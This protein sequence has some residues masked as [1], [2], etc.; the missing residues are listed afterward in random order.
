[1]VAQAEVVMV[2]MARVEA[3]M[4]AAAT[5]ETVP[6]V[7]VMEAAGL[8]TAALEMAMVVAEAAEVERTDVAGW[9]GLLAKQAG[10]E[11]SLDTRLSG[12]CSQQTGSCVLCCSSHSAS[13]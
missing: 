2:V 9:V 7:K 1:M 12:H 3:L 13:K 8:G 6:G 10:V 5:A 4:V 11:G